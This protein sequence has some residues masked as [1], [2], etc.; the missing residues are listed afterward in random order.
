MLSVATPSVFLQNVNI[1]C[2]AVSHNAECHYAEC[3][4]AELAIIVLSLVSQ[5]WECCY[6]ECRQAEC[7]VAFLLSGY[8]I[9]CWAQKSHWRESRSASSVF[10]YK[11]GRFT[12]EHGEDGFIKTV[13][14][15]V[16]N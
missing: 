15:K 10:N 9:K 14:P 1:L 4:Y 7:R 13:E 16:E 2:F 3:L 11:L 12:Y 8:A 5:F 6:A